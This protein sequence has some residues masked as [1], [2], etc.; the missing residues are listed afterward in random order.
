MFTVRDNDYK[1]NWGEYHLL[2][3]AVAACI[4][5]LNTSSYPVFEVFDSDGN[6]AASV[7]HSIRIQTPEEIHYENKDGTS[8][9]PFPQPD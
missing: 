4:H 5:H 9:G 3:M 8:D 6:L 2:A 1:D 7:D